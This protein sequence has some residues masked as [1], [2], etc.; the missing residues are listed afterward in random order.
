MRAFKVTLALLIFTAAAGGAEDVPEPITPVLEEI[1]YDGWVV[2]YAHFSHAA[3]DG[4]GRLY[5]YEN[6][7]QHFRYGVFGKDKWA[8]LKPGVTGANISAVAFDSGGFPHIISEVGTSEE[9]YGLRYAFWD[10]DGWKET[11]IENGTE[12]SGYY[13]VSI[14]M[15][16]SDRVHIVYF[17]Y[18]EIPT[19][20]EFESTYKMAVRYGFWNGREWELNSLK[21]Y[22]AA[23]CFSDRDCTAIAL[24]KGGRP[25][26]CYRYTVDW[27]GLSDFEYA[28][29]T[30][31]LWQVEVIDEGVGIR[32][33]SMEIDGQDR[34]HIAFF[35]GARGDVGYVTKRG[36]R[37]EAEAVETMGWLGAGVS[38]ALDGNGVPYISYFEA[39]REDSYH[40]VRRQ[41][42]LATRYDGVWRVA[43]IQERASD[44]SW[45]H[46]FY[47][48]GKTFI[49]FGPDGYP[50]VVFG[51][52]RYAAWAG[53]GWPPPACEEDFPSQPVLAEY[54][55]FHQW[56]RDGPYRYPRPRYMYAEY[57]DWKYTICGETEEKRTKI[58]IKNAASV[59]IIGAVSIY[60]HFIWAGFEGDQY[61]TW[62]KLRAD[63]KEGWWGG[64]YLSTGTPAA[65][66]IFREP[67]GPL[68]E[69]PAD[70]Y[71][72]IREETSSYDSDS[73]WLLKAEVPAGSFYGLA[74]IYGDW[75]C[76][77]DGTGGGWLPADTPGLEVYGLIAD[78]GTYDG[79]EASFGLYL[80]VEGK[81]DEI[82]YEGY[83]FLYDAGFPFEDPVITVNTVHGT[84]EIIPEDVGGHGTYESSTTY[85]VAPLPRPVKRDEIDSI[86]LAVGIPPYRFEATVDPR[87]AWAEYDEGR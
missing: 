8:E 10:G 58:N 45:H 43:S 79:A 80:P 47:Y 42:K 39:R 71:R 76:V 81:V 46:R 23:H 44:N 68:R 63:E 20:V 15:D 3:Y 4:E 28:V 50:Y 22:V 34:P 70:S 77:G 69:G 26:V 78:W 16:D 61:E 53:E 57:P 38:I 17:R 73:D 11:Y 36:G 59:D 55:R 29:F 49:L 52:N 30:G 41:L 86:S 54:I 12:E 21:S 64:I 74:T 1:I 60:K 6:L 2:R 18:E 65:V 5:A 48:A 32:E 84:F 19:D 35:E 75:F 85:F 27:G 40:D 56:E 37:W 87:P 82:R 13:G 66:V 31:G 33:V 24:D 51:N 14:A 7:P 62:L 9:G 83:G 67:Y 25:R 72:G